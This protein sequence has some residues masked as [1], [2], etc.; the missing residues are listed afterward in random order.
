MAKNKKKAEE[1]TITIN[2]KSYN[3]AD[4]TQGQI[5]NVNHCQ[6]LSRKLESARFNVQQLEGGFAYFMGLLQESLN[7]ESN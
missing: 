1:Q 5:M 2:D 3:V 6:D 7:A 4:L